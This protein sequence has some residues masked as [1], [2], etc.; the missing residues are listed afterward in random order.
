M[1]QKSGMLIKES[2]CVKAGLTS[3]MVISTDKKY[4]NFILTLKFKQEANG[5]SGVFFVQVLKV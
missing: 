4:K 1:V 3:N 2:L 5:N